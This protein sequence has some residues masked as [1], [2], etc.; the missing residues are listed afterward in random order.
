MHSTSLIYYNTHLRGSIDWIL[1]SVDAGGGGSSAY[2][3]SLLG[4]SAPYPETSGY[5]IPTLLNA[6][7]ELDDRSLEVVAIK[8][9]EWLLTLQ[10]KDGWWPCG[11]YKS[12]SSKSG[13]SVFNT[14]QIIDGMVALASHT[15][16]SRWSIAAIRAAN[17]LADA[18]DEQGLWSIG[19][20]RK[21]SNPSYYTHVAWPMLLAWRLGASESIRD[22][23]IRVLQRIIALRTP[24][25]VFR[26]WSFDSDKPAFTHT[27]AY[28]LRGFIECAVLLEDWHSF[29][30]PC[31]AALDRL[32]RKAEFTHGRLPGAYSEEWKPINWYTCLTGNAQ[33]AICLLRMEQH[34]PD[35]RL[36][37]AAEKLI[38]NV[39]NHQ[40]IN[41]GRTK[42][43]GAVSG[44]APLWG[45]YMFMRYPNWAVK[46][47]AD[48]LMMLSHRL[49]TEGLQ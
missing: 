6:S 37:N 29:G 40:R 48:A 26:G 12:R 43:R 39:C 22:A 18:V 8:V 19:N 36:V 24:K 35:L 49:K 17:W 33:I 21:G 34:S 1:R 20:Y 13:P 5:I 2:Y 4:W 27:I 46:Y 30:A 15:G 44:S 45:R 16:D 25:G 42:I 9:G 3:S 10:S 47:H 38:S 41:S 7:N 28:T 23:A 14:G 11:L 31:E 32:A